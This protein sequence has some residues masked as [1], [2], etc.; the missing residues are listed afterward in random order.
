MLFFLC[1]QLRFI[2]QQKEQRYL[3]LRPLSLS[4]CISLLS[5]LCFRVPCLTLDRHNYIRDTLTH[6]LTKYRNGLRQVRTPQKGYWTRS[7]GSRKT[8]DGSS[9][10]YAFCKAKVL[11]RMSGADA[12]ETQ[13]WLLSNILGQSSCIKILVQTRCAISCSFDVLIAHDKRRHKEY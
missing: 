11:E 6:A 7:G 3:C 13:K 4:V 12:L 9:N 5:P 8:T 10:A 1:R 2:E